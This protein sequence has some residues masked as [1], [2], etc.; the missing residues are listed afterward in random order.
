MRH[1]RPKKETAKAPHWPMSCNSVL[2]L[3]CHAKYFEPGAPPN[4][5]PSTAGHFTLP[6]AATITRS[7]GVRVPKATEDGSELM[8]VLMSLPKVFS[9][10]PVLRVPEQLRVQAATVLWS[11]LSDAVRAAKLGKE[12]APIAV[13]AHKIIWAA[14][15]LLFRPTLREY[16]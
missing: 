16:R 2:C 13:L 15:M 14:P 11:L 6:N 9:M 4:P 1:P 8:S 5:A 7:A 12:Q 10:Q 3:D